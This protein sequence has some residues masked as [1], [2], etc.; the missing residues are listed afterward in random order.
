M[1][2]SVNNTYYDLLVHRLVAVAYVPISTDLI[3][4][5]YS[6]ETLEVDHKDSIKSHNN[7]DNLEWVTPEE[8]KRRMFDNNLHRTCKCEEHGNCKYTNEQISTACKLLSEN[9]YTMKEISKITG[10]KYKTISK[11]KS[12]NAFKQISDFYD[13]ESY[14]K[15]RK[16]YTDDLLIN[17]ILLRKNRKDLSIKK[18]SEIY[19]INYNTLKNVFQ[20]KIHK[21]LLLKYYYEK[22]DNDDN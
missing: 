16:I 13:F 15:I 19:C 3:S 18:I 7:S 8:N 21:D 17:A 12:R 6:Y 1:R 5:G 14:N 20:G 9:K 10:I 22:G 11:I 4:K 2:L